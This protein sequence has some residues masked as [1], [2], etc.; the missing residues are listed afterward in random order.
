MLVRTAPPPAWGDPDDT[1]IRR[2]VIAPE[3]DG[4]VSAFGITTLMGE[5]STWDPELTGDLVVASFRETG[6]TIW[7]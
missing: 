3:E 7:G 2:E 5:E 6:Y 4:V 1:I